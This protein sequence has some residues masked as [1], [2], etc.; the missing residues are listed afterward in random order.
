MYCNKAEDLIRP[1]VPESPGPSPRRGG[2][3]DEAKSHT[4]FFIFILSEQNTQDTLL[5]T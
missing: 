1:R 3:G 2:P 4:D 5:L